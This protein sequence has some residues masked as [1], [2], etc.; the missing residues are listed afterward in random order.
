MSSYGNE[1]LIEK[2]TM[3]RKDSVVEEGK[4]SGGKRSR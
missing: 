2:R 3:A 4:I 1:S